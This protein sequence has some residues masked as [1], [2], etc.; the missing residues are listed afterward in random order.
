MILT[1]GILPMD[2]WH[3]SGKI[4]T[5]SSVASRFLQLQSKYS[6]LLVSTKGFTHSLRINSMQ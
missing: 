5:L 2:E 1:I 4:L 6:H 3:N